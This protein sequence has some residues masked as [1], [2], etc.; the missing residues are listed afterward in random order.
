[1]Q[2]AQAHFDFGHDGVVELF[3][4]AVEPVEHL[5]QLDHGAGGRELAGADEVLAVGAGV[6]AVRVLGHDT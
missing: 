4:L 3:Q 5:G 1:V 6:H 2:R